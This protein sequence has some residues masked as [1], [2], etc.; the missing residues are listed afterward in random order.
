MDTHSRRVAEAFSYKATQYDTFGQ[1]HINLTRMRRRVYEHVER[2][3][4]PGDRI[5]ELNAGTGT[6]AVHFASQGF[7]V[8][9]I[10]IS[11][12]MI[13]A[14]AEK[15]ERFNLQG[16]LTFQ[17]CSFSDLSTIKGQPFQYIF[18]NF[19]GLNCVDDLAPVAAQ[20]T[21]VLCPG[22]RLT[23]VV[24]PP[25]SPWDIALALKGEFK[26]AFR[27][28]S[29][30]GTLANVEGVHF[31][32]CYFTPRQA[33]NALGSD[34]HFLRLEGLSVF[35]PPADRKHFA[36]RFPHLYSML[37]RLDDALTPHAPFNRWGDFFILTVEYNPQ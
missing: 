15:Q 16:R 2:F 36:L 20:I 4:R 28:W 22:G 10:D 17:N 12:G 24:M 6:D 19:G 34:F 18:S 35:A 13:Q 8:H 5:L 30:G 3:L 29:P 11:P 7:S 9:A 23:W 37:V 1:G 26:R 32:V 25:F 31:K 27:R 14:I 33:L 21:N